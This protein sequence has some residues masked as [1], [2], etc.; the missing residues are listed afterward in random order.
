MRRA[1]QRQKTAKWSGHWVL[2]LLLCV[3]FNASSLAEVI[4]HNSHDH[5]SHA[6][7]VVSAH[8]EE[9]VDAGIASHDAS[10]GHHGSAAQSQSSSQESE[11]CICEDVC[12][13]SSASLNQPRA[14][15]AAPQLASVSAQAAAGYLSIS[16]DLDLPP[17]NFS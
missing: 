11:E 6:D 15:L 9:T 8:A 7:V 3:L 2:G 12:C 13:L 4:A 1:A 10:H 16:L 5:A 17:P 14:G